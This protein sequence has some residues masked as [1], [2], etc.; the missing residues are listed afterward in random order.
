MSRLSSSCLCSCL[1]GLFLFA[2][3]VAGAAVAPVHAEK[4]LS[5]GLAMVGE[6]TLPRDFTHFPYANPEAPKGG[7]FRMAAMG[8]F[9]TL[10]PFS[11]K[12]TA[13]QSLN[14]AYDRLMARSWGEPFTMYPLIARS[15][16]VTPDRSRIT[17]HLDPRARFSDGSPITSADILFSY[18]TLKVHGR[19]NMRN[20]YKKVDR[21]ET[22]DPQTI[23]FILGAGR[24][25]ETVMILSMMPV[26]SKAFWEGRDFEKTILTPPVTTGP[27]VISDVS[28]GRR[29]VYRKNPRY[30]AADLP[31]N[32]GLYNFDR[33][34]LT[35]FR[36]QTSAF[37]AFQAGD[38][39]VWVDMDP[40]HWMS[41]YNPAS[42][43]SGRIWKG[44]IA[45][46]R[47]EK[48]KGFIFNTRRKPFD[49]RRVRR[50]LSLAL[51]YQWL[52]RNIY[53]DQYEVTRSYFPN[54]DLAAVGK[55]DALELE[56]LSPYKSLLPPE[57]FGPAWMPPE[58]G[59]L[60]AVRANQIEADRLLKEAGWIVRD[61]VRVNK[62]TGAPFR[63][64]LVV[65][66]AEDEKLAISFRKALQRLG[67]SV[68][69][70]T[71]DAA[72]FQDRLSGYEYDMIVYSWQNSLSPGGEQA[73]YWGCGAAKIPGS[74]NY[75]G[76]CH[77]AVEALVGRIPNAAS[78]A[79]MVSLTRALDRVLMWQ[80]YAIPLF[81]SDHDNVAFQSGVTHPREPSLY[82]NI[83][84]SWWARRP[85]A[86]P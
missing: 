16:E 4:P 84:E 12:G 66:T 80:A 59:F 38:L 54:S 26:L 65:G 79:E 41:A 67:V 86:N 28:P 36:D 2:V 18:E 76:I 32:K 6:P 9:D 73:V 20:V 39:D 82:G 49:D 75:A 61:G 43:S 85:S 57:V 21:V 35:Y 13:A 71:L 1:G 64:E 46:H 72:A 68:S 63:F 52:N 17:F 58:S 56:V 29:I 62:Q 78:R 77:P 83:M 31:A 45:H 14:L 42:V 5:E 44:E 33:V 24:D 40:G 81:Y 74:F 48:M 15:A 3:F 55:P 69:L 22:P 53:Y 25:R 60:P 19:P 11:F 10:N 23:T 47:V 7:V 34:E 8:T 70:R 30:W 50:A 37:E 27:Y 51:D